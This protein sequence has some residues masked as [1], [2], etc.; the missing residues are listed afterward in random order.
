MAAASAMGMSMYV[1]MIVLVRMVMVSSMLAARV[2]VRRRYGLS[3]RG[4]SD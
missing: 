4:F 3:R 1:F 2:L